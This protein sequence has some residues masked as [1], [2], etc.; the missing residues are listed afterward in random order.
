MQI[1]FGYCARAVGFPSP[2]AKRGGEGSGVGV[3]S[4]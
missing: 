4:P 2:R 3:F 1:I